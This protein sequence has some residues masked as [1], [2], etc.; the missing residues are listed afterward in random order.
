M[1]ML[2]SDVKENDSQDQGESDGYRKMDIEQRDEC[3][4]G[5]QLLGA[6]EAGEDEYRHKYC[7]DQCHAVSSPRDFRLSLV[8]SATTGAAPAS[9]VASLAIKA[10]MAN[11]KA[12][13]SPNR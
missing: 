5:E 3:Q 9:R 1:V 8:A 12:S 13:T 2:L 10:D 6:G 7:D 11:L 4:D